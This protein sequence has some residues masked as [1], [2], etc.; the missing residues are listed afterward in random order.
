MA[1][2]IVSVGSG[3]GGVGKSVVA[4]NL[5][6][7]L[8]KQGKRVVLADL[9]VGGA[10]AHILFGMLHPPLTLTDFI[11]RRVERLEDVLQ[12]VSAHPFLQLIPG[13]GDTLGHGESSVC[14]EKATH[15]S[16]SPTPSG[17]TDALLDEVQALSFIVTDSV[18]EA[19]ALESN[20]IKQR[21]PKY[22]I[23]LRDDK[24]YPYLQLTT[25]EAF[26]RLLVARR[27]EKD[28]ARLLRAV[29]A[30]QARAPHHHPVAP[31]VRAPVLQRGH[32]RRSAAGPASST[33]SSAASRRASRRSARRT[34]TSA[35]SATRACSS[36]AARRARRRSRRP[37]A[38]R[39]RAERFEQA[40]HWRDA[41]R[42]VETLRDRQQKM[43]TPGL[44][45]RDAFG[46][47]LGPRGA[48]VQV[49]QM[50]AGRVVE[51]VELWSDG[52]LDQAGR[53]GVARGGGRRGRAAAVLRSQSPPPEVHVR[54]PLEDAA[55]LEEWLS[56][57]AGRQVRFVVPKRGEKRACWS[58]P[59]AT[60]R[61]AYDTR[62]SR[63]AGASHADALETLR[64]RAPAAGPAAA[65]R[66]LRHLDIPGQRNRGLDG[67]LRGR[68]DAA[69]EYRKF[70]IQGPAAGRG[71]WPGRASGPRRRA[72]AADA[73]AR[74]RRA[75]RILDDFASMREVVL[76]RYRRSPS[77][78][79][80]SPT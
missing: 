24:S 77:R 10:D 5:S 30:R 12:P 48:V 45:D 14:Q 35:R 2:T 17:K 75:R 44:G 60:P 33:T 50:R 74:A 21:S 47:K 13:T 53:A 43:A 29:P 28:G 57:R 37:D 79:V 68:P 7:L 42:T 8:A 3:K 80:R 38:R 46:V 39:R 69:A 61:F 58:S 62:G 52:A 76:R 6:M 19:L 9:D 31:A 36:R 32:H 51:R 72:E 63:D 59:H 73:G 54:S 34:S 40:A 11:E 26:P 18:V 27:V 71:R 20:L 78:A 16:L 55:R 41:I 56:T 23:L 15:P 65:H 22:N 64:A 25:G 4:A 66:V 67:G 1:T 49:F 70:R